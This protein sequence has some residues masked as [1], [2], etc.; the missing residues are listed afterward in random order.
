LIRTKE[1]RNFVVSY[2]RGKGRRDS[3]T[4]KT[5]HEDPRERTDGKPG[6]KL[7]KEKK[8]ARTDGPGGRMRH[9]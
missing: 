9:S 6:A 5:Q 2:Q 4:D 8:E 1:G 7:K 3:P